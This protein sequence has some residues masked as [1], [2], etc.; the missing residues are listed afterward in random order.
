M[1]NN[2]KGG[3]IIGQVVFG[4]LGGIA[5]EI[6]FL[7][8]MVL[9]EIATKNELEINFLYQSALVVFFIGCFI[10]VLIDG[11]LY[12]KKRNKYYLFVPAV[13]RSSILYPLSFLLPYCLGPIFFVMPLILL[14]L[15]FDYGFFREQR[16]PKLFSESKTQDQ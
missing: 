12:L 2:Q 13:V 7:V 4:I 14:I 8:S 5:L 1:H 10:T 15:S 3:L 9:Y 11:Y 6:L 16:K